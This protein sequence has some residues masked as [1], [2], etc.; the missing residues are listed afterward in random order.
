MK[1]PTALV[2]RKAEHKA[3]HCKHLCRN[4]LLS[5]TPALSPEA[6]LLR[7]SQTQAITLTVAHALKL[8]FSRRYFIESVCALQI[9][10]KCHAL[11]TVP[12]LGSLSFKGQHPLTQGAPMMGAS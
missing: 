1:A 11:F 9:G 4:S 7:P 10:S 8:K 5:D 3:R 6:E 2:S 12:L